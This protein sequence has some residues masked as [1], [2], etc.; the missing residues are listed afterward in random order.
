MLQR[1]GI[2]LTPVIVA[3]L[4]VTAFLG[5]M[6]FSFT[7]DQKPSVK[8]IALY[9][10]FSL[11]EG[12]SAALSG[13][14]LTITLI[15]TNVISS[16][17]LNVNNTLFSSQLKIVKGAS[18]AEAV[19]GPTSGQTASYDFENEIRLILV[20]QDSSGPQLQFQK[21]FKSEADY[22][23]PNSKTLDCMPFVPPVRAQYC[24]ATYLTWAKNH[25]PGFQGSLY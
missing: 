8:T 15:K 20:S 19:L 18:S 23:C 7:N 21:I 1:P 9:K 22:A 24:Q 14:H 16:N 13:Q 12:E 5:V 10:T 3:F 4:A 2:S 6:Y 25:C 11:K 17:S